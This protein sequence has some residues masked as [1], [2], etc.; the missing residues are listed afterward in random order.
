MDTVAYSELL[1]RFG[2]DL[3]SIAEGA[4]AA[5]G[6]T[7]EGDERTIAIAAARRKFDDYAEIIDTLDEESKAL[8]TQFTKRFAASVDMI[9]TSLAKIDGG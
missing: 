8:K 2:K 9:R 1:V 5:A 4:E 6:N 3:V 7:I